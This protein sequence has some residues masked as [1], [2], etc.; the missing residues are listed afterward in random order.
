MNGRLSALS[1][2]AKVFRR[3]PALEAALRTPFTSRWAFDVELLG[4]LLVP[5][6]LPR[7]VEEMF[8]EVPL[9]RWR[10]V[11]GSSLS[12]GQMLNAGADLLRIA[13]QIRRRHYSS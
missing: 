12:P 5:G 3:G 2:G 4:R 7:L 8:V 13:W 10:D 9:Q 11:K 6:D 1:A